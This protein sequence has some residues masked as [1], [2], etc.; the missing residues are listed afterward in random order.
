MANTQHPQGKQ[1][2]L[3]CAAAHRNTGRSTCRTQPPPPIPALGYRAAARSLRRKRERPPLLHLSS[4]DGQQ[5]ARMLSVQS[6]K[7]VRAISQN[8]LISV[9]TSTS[10]RPNP[11]E[12]DALC[13]RRGS[14]ARCA[15]CASSPCWAPPQREVRPDLESAQPYWPVWQKISRSRAAQP[16]RSRAF[17][18]HDILEAR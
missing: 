4:P 16:R 1:K 14:G 18:S 13:H 3:L 15:A 11:C 12:N 2:T 10:A 6:K 9:G 17:R 7:K 5:R 8:A